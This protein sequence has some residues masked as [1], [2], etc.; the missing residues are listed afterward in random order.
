MHEGGPYKECP[1][2]GGDQYTRIYKRDHFSIP[3]GP[4]EPAGKLMIRYPIYKCE[5]CQTEYR[6]VETF[7]VVH[8]AIGEYVEGRLK[9]IERESNQKRNYAR[10]NWLV[11]G[12]FVGTFFAH[13][14][15]LLLRK[16]WI[17]GSVFLGVAVAMFSFLFGG[18]TF[19][20]WLSARR[21]KKAKPQPKVD[22]ALM[23]QLIN[24]PNNEH[25][26]P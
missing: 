16:E 1:G 15:E 14:I 8:A 2:C 25:Q 23:Q 9:A 17:I 21:E 24:E 6:S 12:I 4:L 18:D 5:A 11:A 22:D 7:E 13:G 20:N 3:L 10:Q 19:F 26:E